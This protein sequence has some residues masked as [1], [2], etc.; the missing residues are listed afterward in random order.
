MRAI[1][2]LITGGALSSCTAV[3]PQPMVPTAD[4]QRAY[5]RL[6]AGK[7][8][9]PSVSCVPPH[10]SNDMTIIDRQTVGFRVG[11]G[12]SYRA[13]LSPGCELLGRGGYTMVT[14]Q[15]GG[16]GLCRGQI[17]QV[18]DPL[19]GIGVGSCVIEDIAVFR[20]PG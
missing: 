3:P 20:R 15:Y 1:F 12:T 5:E 17:I 2:L 13:R 10:N 14:R 18:A 8:A 6:F 11:A 9:G 7:V 19:N 4:A 16:G